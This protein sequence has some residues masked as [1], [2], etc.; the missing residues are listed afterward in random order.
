MSADSAQCIILVPATQIEPECEAAL[1]QLEQRG[2]EVRRV[3]GYSQIDVARNE[4]AAKALDDGFDETFWIDADIRF[5]PDDVDRIRSHDLPLCCGIY[6][7]KGLRQL[8]MK[9]LPDTERISFGTNGGLM[10]IMY[11]ATGFLHVRRQVYDD[12]QQQLNLPTCDAFQQSF[13]PYFLPMTREYESGHWY[14]GEDFAFC[15]R[16]RQC[17]YRIMADTSVR[18]WHVGRY[19]YGWE[20]AG[21]SPE[22]YSDYLFRLEGQ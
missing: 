4:I 16:A 3:S 21:S 5:S 11:A 22:R 10:E 6:P 19:A 14:L 12:I 7:K 2:Y 1:R 18:L 9:F 8:A 13:V 17:G 20:D 15:E